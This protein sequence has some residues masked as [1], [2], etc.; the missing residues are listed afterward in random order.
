MEATN[1]KGKRSRR[2]V[3]RGGKRHWAVWLTFGV[4]FGIL[5]CEAFSAINAILIPELSL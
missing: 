3:S 1:V 4:V 2:K 5:I